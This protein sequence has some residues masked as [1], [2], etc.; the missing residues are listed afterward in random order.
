MQLCFTSRFVNKDDGLGLWLTR[1]FSRF[2]K[3]A[4]CTWV[5]LVD[6]CLLFMT[7]E[8]EEMYVSSH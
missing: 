2:S 5:V 6:S 8:Y 1:V 3:E 4:N 7:D